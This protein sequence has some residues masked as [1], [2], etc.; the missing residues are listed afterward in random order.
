LAAL[1]NVFASTQTITVSDSVIANNGSDGIIA[2][3]TNATPVSIMVRNSTKANNR[4]GGL[5][6]GNSGVAVRVTRSTTSGNVN[7]WDNSGAAVLSYGDNNI[8]GSANA[9]TEPPNPLAYK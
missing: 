1:L 7:A 4:S 3:A 8:D 9:N 6:A 2:S 5:E